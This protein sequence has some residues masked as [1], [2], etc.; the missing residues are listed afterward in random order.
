M[1]RTQCQA[2]LDLEAVAIGQEGV[3]LNPHQDRMGIALRL[4]AGRRIQS[5]EQR[6]PKE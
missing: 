3:V 1:A 5:A 4:A 6:C 2:F